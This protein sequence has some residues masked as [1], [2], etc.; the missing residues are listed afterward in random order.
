MR[1]SINYCEICIYQYGTR[2]AYISQQTAAT[3]RLRTLAS[4]L[5]QMAYSLGTAQPWA[6]RLAIPV[7]P[8]MMSSTWNI[9][10]NSSLR[11][12]P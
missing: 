9:R 10:K 12:Q 5:E 11:R 8:L 1:I 2:F 3:D 4:D 7:M 6:Q